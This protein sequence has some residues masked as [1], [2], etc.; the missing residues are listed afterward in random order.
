M[1][2]TIIILLKGLAPRRAWGTILEATADSRDWIRT[3]DLQVLMM[4]MT[5]LIKIIVMMT[6]EKMTVWMLMLTSNICP[7]GGMKTWWIVISRSLSPFWPLSSWPRGERIVFSGPNTNTNTIRFQKCGQIRI[8]ILFGFRKMAEYE[9]EY[10][11]GSEIWP[12]TN[13]NTIRSATFVRI[14]IRIL[15]LFE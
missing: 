7:G 3:M 1:K 9:Y 4:I 15:R 14:R 10:Y 2:N 5:V 12:N 11:S 13:T 8:R 6:M